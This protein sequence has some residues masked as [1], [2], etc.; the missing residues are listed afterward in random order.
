MICCAFNK[1][2]ETEQRIPFELTARPSVGNSSEKIDQNFGKSVSSRHT[3]KARAFS[4]KALR[5]SAIFNRIPLAFGG[6]KVICVVPRFDPNANAADSMASRSKPA[7]QLES[8]G[9]AQRQMSEKSGN[10]TNILFYGIM[11]VG[12]RGFFRS[13]AYRYIRTN[14]GG[15]PKLWEGGCYGI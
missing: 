7:T 6:R 10:R 1:Q 8:T 12:G 13:R 14:I 4:R 5:S 3:S 11:H 9:I 2:A 15:K